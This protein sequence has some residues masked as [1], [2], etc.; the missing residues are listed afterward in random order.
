MHTHRWPPSAR[1]APRIPALASPG[2]ASTVY[3]ARMSTRNG[4]RVAI[5]TILAVILLSGTL[6]WVSRNYIRFFLSFES[7]GRNAQGYVYPPRR[8]TIA[9]CER[10]PATPSPPPRP[11][12]SP[13]RPAHTWLTRDHLRLAPA[14]E[15][16]GRNAH[17]RVETHHRKT[18]FPL[19]TCTPR[20][21]R[22][23][24]AR[25]F[26]AAPGY[27]PLRRSSPTW[28]PS[29]RSHAYSVER[30]TRSWRAMTSMLPSVWRKS[31]VR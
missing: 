9:T 5:V 14:I 3:D 22:R 31:C 21:A 6:V 26:G 13:P 10:A 29:R 16:L 2:G 4:R 11:P 8:R 23:I 27:F 12:P 30:C 7:I 24:R 19:P 20:P 1:H 18:G 17:G 25:R 15:S 28:T